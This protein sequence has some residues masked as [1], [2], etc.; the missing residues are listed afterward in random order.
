MKKAQKILLPL[1][2]LGIGLGSLGAYEFYFSDKINTVDVVVA[3]E[4]IDFKEALTK[5]NIEIATIR[6]DTLVEGAITPIDMDII[7]E[8]NAAIK[9]NKGAQIYTDLIDEYDLIPNEKEGEFIAPIPEEWLFAVPGSLRKT[10]IADFYAIPDKE[11]SVIRS[12][13]EDSQEIAIDKDTKTSNNEATKEPVKSNEAVDSKVVS[14]NKPILS[15]V[16]VA[17][18]KDDSNT[19]VKATEENVDAATGSVTNLEIIANE[20]NLN[21][22]REYTEKG[23]KLYVVYKYER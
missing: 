16:R 15:N 5:E 11:Q 18:V 23:Y 10:F 20:D 12:L 21:T 19:E 1:L 2:F 7:L 8:K 14:E 9:I 17:S 13:I 6:K 22:L 3:K 4:N